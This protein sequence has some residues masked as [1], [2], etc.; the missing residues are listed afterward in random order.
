VVTNLNTVCNVSKPIQTSLLYTIT[1]PI[2][3]SAITEIALQGAL[4]LAKSGRLGLQSYQIR[5]KMQNK[6][7][8]TIQGHRRQ[9]Q[10]KA[11]MRLPIQ[12]QIQ[13]YW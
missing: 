7:Y 9:Y 12:I 6:G 1:I 5:W 11:S 10:S 4:V 3:R 2:T 8:Y 13:F